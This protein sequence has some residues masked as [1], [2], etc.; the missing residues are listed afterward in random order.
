MKKSPVD[1]KRAAA[2]AAAL[3]PRDRLHPAAV[4]WADER[5]PAE[6]WAVALSGGADSVGLLL[7]L[8]AHWPKRRARL[9]AFHFDHRLRGAQSAADARFCARACA[10]LGVPLVSGSWRGARASR[11]EAD[12][13]AAR[14]DFFR[15]EMSRRRMRVLWLGHQQDDIAETML[16]R[17]ARGSGGSGLAAPRAVHPFPPD[18]PGAGGRFHIRPLLSVKKSQIAAAVRS[19]G[20]QWREDSSNRKGAYFRNRLRLD[21][22]PRWIRASG[23]DALGGAALSRELLEEDDRALEAWVDLIKPIG[24]DGSL[25]ASRL[26]GKPRA[27]VRRALYRWLLMVPKA[28][29][30]S[31]QGFDSLL[32]A[33]ERGAPARHSLGSH[34]FA[35]IRAACLRFE[36]VRRS[37]RLH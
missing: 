17:L 27:V 28:G 37:R 12:A 5:P 23:R 35:V 33:L 26:A 9:L 15:R 18:R 30:L 20:A 36:T 3:I 1:W 24:P 22:V 25:S 8:W 34:G 13:R 10:D 7:L 6:R 11:S 4:G 16:M 19:S 2:A 29:E 21:V 31:R 14:F 32:R